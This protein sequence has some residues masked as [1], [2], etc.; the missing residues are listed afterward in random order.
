[1]MMIIMHFNCR[2]LF[3]VDVVQ[4][5]VQVMDCRQL[6]IYRHIPR[7]N[8]LHNLNRKQN[9]LLW[10]RKVGLKWE[11]GVLS[12]VRTWNWNGVKRRLFEM[13]KSWTETYRLKK[14]QKQARKSKIESNLVVQFLIWT[15]LRGPIAITISCTLVGSKNNAHQ[16]ICSFPQF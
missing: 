10:M 4:H 7:T 1:M 8:N 15:L 11:Y 6:Q 5:L 3:A 13:I 16:F 12:T 2:W 9:L 14:Y